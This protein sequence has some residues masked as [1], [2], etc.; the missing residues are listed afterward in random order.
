MNLTMLRTKIFGDGAELNGM[1]ELYRQPHIK[2]FTTN[3]TLM[4]KAGVDDYETFA[5]KV[6]AAIPD[7]PVS[8]EVFADDFASMAEQARAIA[9]WAPNVNVTTAITVPTPAT[10]A[11]YKGLA[12]SGNGTTHLLYA[13]DFRNTSIASAIVRRDVRWSS[14]SR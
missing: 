5:R 6:L 10:N 3:P 9:A 2:G 13:T 7:R 11:N 1:L 14:Q 12:L 4:R 8:F